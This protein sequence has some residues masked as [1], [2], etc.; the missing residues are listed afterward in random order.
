MKHLARFAVGTALLGADI[1]PAQTWT[2]QNPPPYP[3]T[4]ARRAGGL[5][6]HPS[7]G[8][9]VMYGGLQSGTTLVLNDTWLWNGVT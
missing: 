8:G 4:L 9:V 1:L 3:T 5:A 2:L 6:W 7:T